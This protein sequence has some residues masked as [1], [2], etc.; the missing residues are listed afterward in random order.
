MLDRWRTIDI[1]QPGVEEKHVVPELTTVWHDQDQNKK[2]Q[3]EQEYEKLGKFFHSWPKHVIF[4][5]CGF[6]LIY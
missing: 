4:N 5:F 2:K 3:C 1:G 6:I